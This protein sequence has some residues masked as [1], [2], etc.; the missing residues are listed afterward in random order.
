MAVKGAKSQTVQ[1]F[2]ILGRRRQLLGIGPQQAQPSV[3]R[4]IYDHAMGP[5]A[6]H[7]ALADLLIH[8]DNPQGLPMA[9]EANQD[10]HEEP[11]K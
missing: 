8:K 9:I 3:G 11:V 10:F 4:N 7:N 1:Y 6:G 5:N 2:G